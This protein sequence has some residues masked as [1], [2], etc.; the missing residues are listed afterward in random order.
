MFPL[1]TVEHL[2]QFLTAYVP[3]F[4]TT[5]LAATFA[6]YAPSAGF[7]PPASASPNTAITVSPAPETSKTSCARV[8]MCAT[9]SPWMSESP[10]DERVRTTL[11]MPNLRMA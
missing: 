11:R 2:Q 3:S 5:T 7:S 8:G 10:F 4:E 9:S 1:L 6:R